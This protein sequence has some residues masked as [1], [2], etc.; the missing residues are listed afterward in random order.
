MQEVQAKMAAIS[1]SGLWNTDLGSSDVVGR[2]SRWGKFKAK[3]SNVIVS[4]WL[5][6]SNKNRLWSSRSSRFFKAKGKIWGEAISF[7][8]LQP[9]DKEE[10]TVQ[11]PTIVVFQR[12]KMKN[13][14]F[15]LYYTVYILRKHGTLKMLHIEDSGA[16]IDVD[17]GGEEDLF[18]GD[19]A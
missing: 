7:Y 13:H 1:L 18:D 5:S 11:P 12:F 10:H 14:T 9:D 16:I 6:E 8:K 19:D 4:S 17:E 3:H 2:I 15:N